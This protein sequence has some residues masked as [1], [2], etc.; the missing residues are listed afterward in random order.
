MAELWG[1]QT[2]GLVVLEDLGLRLYR[3]DFFKNKAVVATGQCSEVYFYKNPK[4]TMRTNSYSQSCTAA[5]TGHYIYTLLV[6]KKEG[7][8]IEHQE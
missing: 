8:E 2:Q 7:V 6:L 4:N 5:C 1:A 3:E